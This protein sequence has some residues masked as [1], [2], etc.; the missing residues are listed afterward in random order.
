MKPGLDSEPLRSDCSCSSP[1]L[2][3]IETVQLL[4]QEIPLKI[5]DLIPAMHK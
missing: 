2:P 1:E 3:P 4:D 5:V